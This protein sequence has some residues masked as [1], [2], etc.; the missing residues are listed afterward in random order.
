MKKI[1]FIQD[2]DFSDN[3]ILYGMISH[4]KNDFVHCITDQWSS[5]IFKFSKV[6]K[7][8]TL[9]DPLLE[10]HY[11]LAVNF[12]ITKESSEI[13]NTIK[14][15][16]KNGYSYSNGNILFLSKEADLHYRARHLGIPTDHNLFQLTYGLA[17]IP[18]KGDGYNL[19]YYP[20]NKQENVVGINIFQK[21]LKDKIISMDYEYINVPFKKNILKQI[22][23][24][25]KCKKLITDNE[26][27]MHIGLALRKKVEF[28]SVKRI[29][30]KV[31]MFSSGSVNYI[32]RNALE[33]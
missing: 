9:D 17:N 27:S 1:V 14:A 4:F 5:G 26:G 2:G 32:D 15:D 33:S 3:L 7:I 8:S 21:S 23:E 20:R 6:S 24:V 30:Y 16:S 25:N 10:E 29:P 11:D 22:D 18:W 12:G 13:F 19:K 31:E 28:L